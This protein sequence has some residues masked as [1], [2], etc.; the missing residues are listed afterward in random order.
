[1]ML[2]LSFTPIPAKCG[3]WVGAMPKMERRT[4]PPPI[5]ATRPLVVRKADAARSSV[6]FDRGAREPWNGGPDTPGRAILPTDGPLRMPAYL[7]IILPSSPQ[8]SRLP[9]GEPVPLLA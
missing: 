7:R 4:P 3:P 6:A 2:T 5:E 1:M 9:R 8:K